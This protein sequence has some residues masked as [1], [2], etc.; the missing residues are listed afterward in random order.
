MRAA[1]SKR[2]ELVI[3]AQEVM[4][5]QAGSWHPLKGKHLPLAGIRAENPW[6]RTKEYQVRPAP[7]PRLLAGEKKA[8]RDRKEEEKSKG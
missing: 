5:L 2:E 3:S 1:S 4:G 7:L 6:S 8:S